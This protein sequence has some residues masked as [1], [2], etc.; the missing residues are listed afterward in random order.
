MESEGE[1]GFRS[2]LPVIVHDRL[3]GQLLLNGESLRGTWDA[4]VRSD[5]SK[6]VNA[7]QAA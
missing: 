1:G 6:S 3:A 5:T 4:P 2:N 7:Q